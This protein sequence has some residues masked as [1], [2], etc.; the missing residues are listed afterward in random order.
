M[1]MREYWSSVDQVT[2]I[3]KPVEEIIL[4]LLNNKSE[5]Y[6]TLSRLFESTEEILKLSNEDNKS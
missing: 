6:P 1:N 2:L 5:I 3:N 4:K